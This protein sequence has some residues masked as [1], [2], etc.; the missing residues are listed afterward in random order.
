MCMT[1]DYLTGDDSGP[2]LTTEQAWEFYNAVFPTNTENPFK[3]KIIIT[4]IP[5]GMHRFHDLWSKL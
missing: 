5:A 2:F 3:D 4:E 1:V